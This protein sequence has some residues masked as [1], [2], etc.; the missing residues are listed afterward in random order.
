MESWQDCDW[1]GWATATTWRAA[2]WKA[3]AIWACEF[4]V[5]TPPGYELD[6]GFLKEAKRD[7]PTLELTTTHD[8]RAAVRDAAAVYTDVWA[9]MGQEAESEKRKRDFADYQVN[10]KLMAAAPKDAL[11]MHCLP[12][13]RGEEVTDE[14]IDSPKA[15][16]W[17][18]PPTGCTCRRASWCG[19]WRHRP[20]DWL[21]TPPGVCRRRCHQSSPLP[22]Q[23]LTGKRERLHVADRREDRRDGDAH[24]PP[25]GRNDAGR[26]H[27]RAFRQASE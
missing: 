12:A 8:P 2:W 13:H 1:R 3:A 26:R 5:C 25:V 17:R 20:R 11:F 22:V 9:S 23:R 24:V 10:A 4:S 21:A 18:R 15:W 14:V 19:C 16:S 27:H 6:A 7:C